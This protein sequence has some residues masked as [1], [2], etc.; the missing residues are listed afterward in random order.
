MDGWTLGYDGYAPAREGLREVLCALGNGVI[1]SRGA[2]TFAVAADG[3]YPATYLAGGYDRAVS[4]VQGREIENE[5]LVNLPNWL[6]LTFAIDGG[7]WVR[8][9]TV[10]HLEHSRRLDLGDGVLT[11]GLR[12]ADA[13]GRITRLEERRLVSMHQPQL[14]ALEVEITPENW[15]GTLTLRAALDGSVVNAGVARYRELEGRHLETLA[16]GAPDGLV[17]LRSRMR[18]SRLEVALAARMTV[19]APGAVGPR[20]VEQPADLVVEEVDVDARAGETLRVEKV[21]AYVSA[22]D[23]AVSE[24]VN[25]AVAAVRRAEPFDGL[26]AAHR[27]CWKHLW[28][29]FDIDLDADGDD[30]DGDGDGDG[31]DPRLELRLH[32]FHL[33]QTTSP[34]TA[35]RDVGVPPRGWHGEAYRGHV[36]WD[37]M[38]VLPSLTL[39]LPELA[40]ALIAYRYRR[41]PAARRAA[42][43]AGFKGAMFPWQSG[44]N[45]REESQRF[46]LNPMSGRWV[47]DNSWRQRHIGAAVAYNAWKYWQITDD[48]HFLCDH[49]AE[50]ILAIARF[51]A[52]IATERGDGRFDIKGVM[53]PDEFHTAYP[54]AD[55]R[56]EGGLDNNAYTNVMA[57]WVLA[58][59]LEVLDLLPEQRRRELVELLELDDAERARFERVSRGLVVPFH[60][61]G[62]ISQFEGFEKLEPFPFADYHARYASIRRL[63]RI[64]EREGDDPNRYQVS[65][66]ADVLMLFYLFSTEELQEIFERLGYAFTPEMIF[67][68]IC[69]YMDR[70]VHG[71]TLSWLTH[72]WVLARADRAQSW[73]LALTALDSDV[74]DLQGGTTPEGVHLGAM[75]G[76]VDLMERCYTG[77]EVRAHTLVFNP[78]LPRQVRRLKTTVRYRRHALDVDVDHDTLAVTSRPTTAA[79]VVVAYRSS[80][81][82]LAPGQTVTFTLVP[83]HKLDRAERVVEQQR[84]A[85]ERARETTS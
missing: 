21:A 34:H 18:Q 61:D 3:H 75:A 37:E 33:L 43:D 60:G 80:T 55:A 8:P 64:L 39:R 84:V 65:K 74:A 11:L 2:L 52:D 58:R 54:G 41:L 19:A 17:W 25:E 49:G 82:A 72:A 62:I 12:L 28:D 48:W 56:T 79:P 78:H 83:E 29:A 46:H 40:R 7:P 67:K 73:R 68:N 10:R 15:S 57:A 13:E 42:H 4:T 1:V 69:W 71:S 53:G 85:R 51:W 76:T 9:D 36:M 24:P 66:Q 45:G 77:L 30:D 59:A 81:R 16:T 31:D 14:A 5:D 32:R 50:L 70:T 20:R 38:F 22:R 27:N 23:A 35:Q 47:P 63:D 6:P 26:A 44:S